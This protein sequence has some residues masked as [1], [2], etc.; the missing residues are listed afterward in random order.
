MA[1]FILRFAVFNFRE[2]PKFYLYRGRDDKAAKVL[3]QIA[4]FNKR[5][6]VITL[7]Y[8]EALTDDIDT[9]EG[10]THKGAIL[11]GGVSASDLTWGQRLK[12]EAKRY[13]MLFATWGVA[14]MTILTWFTYMFDYL[15]F[16]AAGSYIPAIL[17]AKGAQLGVSV[18]ETYRNYI[19]IYA[20]GIVGALLGGAL[21]T[22]PFIGRKWGM[23]ISS[24]LQGVSLFLFATAST[25]AA[26][27]GFNVLEYFMQT[28]FNAIL[29]A[30]TPEIFPAPIRGTACG[31]ASFFGRIFGIVAPQISGHILQDTTPLPTDPG[32][33][34]AVLYFAGAAVWVATLCILA[35]PGKRMGAQSF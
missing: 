11:G 18:G 29:Y 32:Y 21:W 13:K 3:Q 6:P 9:Y 30:W 33:G 4:H 10:S 15:S 1:V 12:L 8:F 5:E 16:S 35:M 22:V 17:A 20:P 14:Y 19:I 24:I 28:L 23:V 34:N 7:E 26:Y 2:S 25:E 31:M 27:I